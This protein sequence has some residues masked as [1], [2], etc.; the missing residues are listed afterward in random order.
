M[1]ETIGGGYWGFRRMAV[2]GT[3]SVSEG[4]SGVWFWGRF[5]PEREEVRP[6]MAEE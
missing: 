3:G 1:T 5:F 2:A 4:L 6:E